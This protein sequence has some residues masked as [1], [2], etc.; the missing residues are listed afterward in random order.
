MEFF[1]VEIPVRV[2][3][4]TAEK[5]LYFLMQVKKVNLKMIFMTVFP[6]HCSN[7]CL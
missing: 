2:T 1:E 4:Q 7:W 6:V 3:V 5:Y